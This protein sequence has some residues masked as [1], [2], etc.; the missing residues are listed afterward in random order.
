MIRIKLTII[1]LF[2]KCANLFAFDVFSDTL[3]IPFEHKQSAIV[4]KN[5]LAA[6][7]SVVIILNE[8]KDITLSIEGYAYVDEGNDTIC[9]YLSLNRALFVR[10]CIT[11]RGIDSSRI[12]FIKAMGQWTPEKKGKYKVNNDIHSRVELLLIYPPPPPVIVISDM[13]ED[14]IADSEDGCPDKYGYKEN[15][16][17]PLKDVTLINFDFKQTYISSKAFPVLDKLL[18]I[19]KE[20]NAYTISL[21]SH[22]SKDEGIRSVCERLAEQRSDILLKYVGSRNFVLSRISSVTNYGKSK[23]VNAQRNP[24]EISDNASVEIILNRNVNL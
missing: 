18:G 20:N 16:G 4:H 23:P 9:K 1:F 7:D 19:L 5:T 8:N 21:R 11:G 14:G 15:N 2:I 17:C 13:D 22:A 24:Q 12:T 10:D 6:L 3:V